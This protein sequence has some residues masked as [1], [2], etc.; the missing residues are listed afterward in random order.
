MLCSC[1]DSMCSGSVLDAA[2]CVWLCVLGGSFV[3]R[4]RR[5]R[6][7]CCVVLREP[8]RAVCCIAVGQCCV[9]WRAVRCTS[10]TGLG[11]ELGGAAECA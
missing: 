7:Q 5:R 11:G 3:G 10:K 8:V 6:R 4:V 2:G 9:L 1:A